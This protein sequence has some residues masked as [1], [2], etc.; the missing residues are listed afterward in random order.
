MF[1]LPKGFSWKLS[2]F[3]GKKQ[4]ATSY[5][6]APHVPGAFK[7]KTR[8]KRSLC[9]DLP[10]ASTHSWPAVFLLAV[11]APRKANNSSCSEWKGS[12][13]QSILQVQPRE[14][15]RAWVRL[16]ADKHKTDLYTSAFSRAVG[17]F[18]WCLHNSC[19]ITRVC[20]HRGGANPRTLLQ[21]PRCNW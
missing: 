8:R 9:R 11:T 13:S 19:R 21:L 16:A 4:K 17:Y 12:S 10:T 7:V 6:S 20:V 15:I 1:K 5:H 18:T 3:H 2:S 14:S